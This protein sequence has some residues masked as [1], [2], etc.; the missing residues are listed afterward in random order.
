MCYRHVICSHLVLLFFLLARRPP[1]ATRIDTLL[2]DTTLFRSSGRG[3]VAP[4]HFRR[5]RL[6]STCPRSRSRASEGGTRLS[7]SSARVPYMRA[8]RRTRSR[9]EE[10]TSEPQSLMR[11]SSDVFCLRNKNRQRYNARTPDLHSVS[12]T[13]TLCN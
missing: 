2:P 4:A 11:I 3:A 6:A 7:D 5:T 8:R 9:S 13:P 1:G 12:N 10:H